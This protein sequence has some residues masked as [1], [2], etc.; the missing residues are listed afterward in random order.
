MVFFYKAILILVPIQKYIFGWPS[1]Q[2]TTIFLI[3]P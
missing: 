2:C 3:K 1:Q